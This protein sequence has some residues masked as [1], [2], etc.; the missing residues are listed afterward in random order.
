MLLAK[1]ARRE[2]QQQAI[3]VHLTT[4]AKATVV[5][6]PGRGFNRERAIFTIAPRRSVSVAS[7]RWPL[8][9]SR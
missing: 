7:A 1:T 4:F 2:A 8:R 5:G 6:A 3:H 9:V